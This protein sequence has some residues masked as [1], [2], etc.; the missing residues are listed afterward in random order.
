MAYIGVDLHSDKFTADFRDKTNND[1]L[2]SYYIDRN[3]IDNF[4]K[5]L[6]K[7]DYIFI[8]ASTP[9][10]AFIDLL[11]DTVKKAIVID[12]FKFSKYI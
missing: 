1:T 5:G 8:E 10:F 4:R 7:D 2:K 9:T 3:E 11:K 6:N 12:P